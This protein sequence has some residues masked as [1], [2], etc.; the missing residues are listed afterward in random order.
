VNRDDRS[1]IQRV[2]QKVDQGWKHLEEKM[3]AIHEQN[4]KRWQRQEDWNQQFDGRL[5]DQEQATNRRA[6][7][8]KAIAGLLGLL[9]TIGT[10]IAALFS[11]WKL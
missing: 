1:D 4:E 8:M 9:G 11:P 3:D 6:G 5:R 2:E 10:I 7:F